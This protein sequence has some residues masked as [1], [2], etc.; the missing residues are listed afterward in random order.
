MYAFMSGSWGMGGGPPG[1]IQIYWIHTFKFP[2][3]GLGPTGKQN[4]PSYPPLTGKKLWIRAL[5]SVLK[6]HDW[7]WN[8]FPGRVRGIILFS[9]GRVVGSFAACRFYRLLYYENIISFNFPGRASR[10]LPIQNNTHSQKSDEI[11]RTRM[12]LEH[13]VRVWELTP[14]ISR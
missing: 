12:S 6:V 11:P 10:P 3:I 13:A 9:G 5:H 1:K 7:I 4:Y 8:S 2:K 14:K